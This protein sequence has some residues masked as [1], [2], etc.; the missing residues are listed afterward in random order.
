M[1]DPSSERD[2]TGTLSWAK[3]TVEIQ[4]DAEISRQTICI[5]IKVG[6]LRK[7][8][9]DP[10][11]TLKSWMNDPDNVYIG[12]RGIIVIDGKRFPERDSIWANPYKVGRDGNREEVIGKYRSYIKEKISREDLK[13]ELLNL[14]GKVLGCW[15]KPDGCHGDVLIELLRDC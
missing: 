14:R 11:I 1:L 15:C 12:R 13:Q 8:Y 7:I 6:E 10:R 2:I 3:P 9:N 4:R 5:N